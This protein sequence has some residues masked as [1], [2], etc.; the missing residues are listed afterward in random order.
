M[1]TTR[2]ALRLAAI[3]VGSL[4]LAACGDFLV[5]PTNPEDQAAAYA[6]KRGSD[7]G[8]PDKNKSCEPTGGARKSKN[9]KNQCEGSLLVLQMGDYGGRA[10]VA[11][12][13]R[14]SIIFGAFGLEE[15]IPDGSVGVFKLLDQE[16]N[17]S[18]G[19]ETPY[20]PFSWYPFFFNVV[21]IDGIRDF[22]VFNRDIAESELCG[23]TATVTFAD[24]NIRVE[25][26]FPAC[27]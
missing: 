22:V 18:D 20:G 25:Y 11:P 16:F 13:T 24:L 14:K 8:T 23:Q 7:P 10:G 27:G 3:A 1:K 9:E 17:V 15:F 2:S 12:Y 19:A 21:K 26:T 5:A 4:A 6:R